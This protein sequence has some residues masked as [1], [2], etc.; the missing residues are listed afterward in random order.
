MLR[1]A[2]M[3]EIGLVVSHSLALVIGMFAGYGLASGKAARPDDRAVTV[4][5]PGGIWR[6]SE[7]ERA[8]RRR[9]S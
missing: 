3:I 2:R 4:R 5:I 7:W 1:E 8:I 9:K 6:R